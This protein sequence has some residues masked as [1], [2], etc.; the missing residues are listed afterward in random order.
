[1]G[2]P[3]GIPDENVQYEGCRKNYQDDEMFHKKYFQREA[4]F[5]S[6]WATN[7][8]TVSFFSENRI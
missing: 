2:Q 3:A 8:S 7:R 5:T 1:V 6:V 4:N